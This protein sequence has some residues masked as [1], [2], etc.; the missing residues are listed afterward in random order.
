VR[1]W[2]RTDQGPPLWSDD[3]LGLTTADGLNSYSRTYQWI[4]L[5]KPRCGFL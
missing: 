4:Q 2:D 1:P 5:A 3:F